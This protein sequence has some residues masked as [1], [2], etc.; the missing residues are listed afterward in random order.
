M[1]VAVVTD[2]PFVRT[3]GGEVWTNGPFSRRFWLRYRSAFD[4][5]RVVGRVRERDRVN[6]G[7]LRV[8]GEH[9]VVTGLPGARGVLGFVRKF[10]A[11]RSALVRAVPAD[12][13]VIL[14]LPALFGTFLLG[15]L[16]RRGQPYGVEVVGDPHEVFAAEAMRHP[17]R[18]LLRRHFTAALRR[19]CLGACAAAYVS[20]R[21]LPLRY[22]TAQ[23][24]FQTDYSS[25][26][27]TDDAFV[28]EPRPAP[29]VTE[30]LTV[31]TVGSLSQPYKGIDVLIDAMARCVADGLDLRLVVVGDGQYMDVLRERAWARGLDARV[32]FL[33]KLPGPAAV[34]AELDRATLFVL[35][36]RTEG[37]P[38]AA[39]EAMARGLPCIGTTV[40]GFPDLLSPADM[41]PPGDVEALY[42][43]IREVAA[44]PARMAEMSRRNL[45]RARDYHDEVLAVRRRAFYE[46]VREQTAGWLRGREAMPALA[47]MSPGTRA[48]GRVYA[49]AKRGLDILGALFGLIATAG[50]WIGAALAIRATLGSPVFFRDRRPGRDGRPFTLLKLRTMREPTPAEARLGSDGA[51]LTR[52][53][54]LLRST[55]VDELPSLWNVLR[56]DMSLVG[57]RPLLMQYL[58]RY[59]PEQARRHEVRPGLTGWAQVHG[60]NEVEWTRRFA[61]DVWYVDHRSFLLDLEILALTVLTVLGRRGISARGHATMGE[62]MGSAPEDAGGVADDGRA[63]GDIGEDHGAGA[64][65]GPRADVHAGEHGAAGADPGAVVDPHAAAEDRPR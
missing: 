41:V 57:P 4:S 37:L 20:P 14:R 28:A 61:L 45:Q 59:T 47:D 19:E 5:V 2:I 25:I 39:I 15:T 29:A 54:R 21:V 50:L 40:G 9:V 23:G 49:A 46:V 7:W 51:R 26:E 36:S 53:G 52:L 60:R 6:A 3:P 33:G 13:A 32:E 1:E 24:G 22:P 38:R 56:G 12:A 17:L 43:T 31:V 55:S 63:G 16:R 48:G 10:I 18:P 27:L 62:F 35:A 34:R 30:P 44:D 42:R 58:G 64:D 65:H 11:Y 8:D